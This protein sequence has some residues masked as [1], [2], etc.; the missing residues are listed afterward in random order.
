MIARQPAL[1]GFLSFRTLDLPGV[2][3]AVSTR[4]AGNVSFAVAGADPAEVRRNRRR[5]AESLEIDPTWLVCPEQVHG[6]RVA[7]VGRGD[8]GRGASSRADVV[9]GA[10]ALIA[11]EPGVVPM[12]LFADCVPVLLIDPRRP[13]IGVAHA[14]WK[15]TV[16]QIARRTVEAMA[17]ELGSEP[18]DLRAAIGPAIGGCCYEVSDEVAQAVLAAAGGVSGRTGRQRVA[19]AVPTAGDRAT[20]PAAGGPIDGRI[21]APAPEGAAEHVVHVGPHG[22]PHVD[23]AAANR[24]QLLAAGLR[25]ENVE[26]ARICTSCQVGRFFSHRAEQGRAGRHAALIGLRP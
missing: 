12:L 15:G 21:Q 13:A 4:A 2:V 10:D 6:N 20:G 19:D 24:R 14:G 22:R 18:G 7:R 17:R 9:A 26:V 3:Q 23:L 16:G 1:D 25:P 11:D 5:L 8:R